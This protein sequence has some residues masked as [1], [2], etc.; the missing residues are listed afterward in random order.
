MGDHVSELARVSVEEYEGIIS[1]PELMGN[2]ITPVLR[3]KLR[4]VLL[5]ARV[6]IRGYSCA[7]PSS[8]SGSWAYRGAGYG[9]PAAGK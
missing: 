5:T 4:Q 9:T 8:S 1:S 6:I 2:P 3:G 7:R